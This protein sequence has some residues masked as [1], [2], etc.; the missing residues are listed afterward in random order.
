MWLPCVLL[1]S[2]A[3]A[4]DVP[5][6]EETVDDEHRRKVLKHK[7][8][9]GEIDT[10]NGLSA[11]T[12]VGTAALAGAGALYGVGVAYERDVFHGLLAIEFAL[13]AFLGQDSTA[14]LGEIVIEKPIEITD[15]VA[16][17]FGGGIIGVAHVE[18]GKGPRPGFGALTMVGV[19]YEFTKDWELFV[20]LDCA[21]I[22][23]PA[24]ILEAD[25]G[26]GVM[27]RF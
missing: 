17:Y 9:K 14:L 21:L 13:E 18:E 1:L 8:E 19:E 20:E 7:P 15:E 11:R 26:A 3:V 25:I 23:A 2:A 22:A 27:W 5:E 12:L 4:T 16:I 6:I 24:P 10:S